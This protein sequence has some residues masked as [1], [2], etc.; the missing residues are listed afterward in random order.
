MHHCL[1]VSWYIA[2]FYNSIT[3]LVM[4]IPACYG[5]VQ[6]HHHQLETRFVLSYLMLLV[7]GVGST[8]FHMTLQ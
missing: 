4:I 2:E 7:V 3:N 8:L 6:T 5:L 1:Q